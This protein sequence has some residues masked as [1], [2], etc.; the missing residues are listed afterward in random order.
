[1]DMGPFGA[2]RSA[3]GNRGGTATRRE[4]APAR[5]VAAAE[6][7]DHDEPVTHHRNTATMHHTPIARQP[8]RPKW[9]VWLLAALLV[10]AVVLIGWLAT[11]TAFVDNGIDSKKYQAV[12]FTNGQVYF[13]KLVA[14]NDTQFKLTEVFYV[15][16]QSD[17]SAE[18]SEGEVTTNQSDMRLI[19]MGNEVHGPEDAM[20]IERAQVL[21]YEN[22]KPDG[23]V[24]QIINEYND[25]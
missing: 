25:K 3:S 9:I 11:R 12:F 1:M 22:L 5:A 7:D 23:K 16:S 8:K 13:G 14:L 20:I 10:L 18:K 17:T 15:Q 6:P 24:T 19:K 4:P 2:S 21:F